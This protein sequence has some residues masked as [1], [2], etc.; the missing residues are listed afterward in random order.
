MQTINTPCKK[1]CTLH[2]ELQLCTGCGRTLEEIG[3]WMALSNAERIGL[4][5]IARQ[6][7]AALPNNT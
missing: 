1:I 6:R 7:L 2:P 3:R 4:I 5:A